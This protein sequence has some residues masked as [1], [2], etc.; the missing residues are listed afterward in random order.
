MMR[1]RSVFALYL[2]LG[3][4]GPTRSKRTSKPDAGRSSGGLLP[5]SVPSRRP[6]RSSSHG[7]AI[8][9]SDQA[10]V[11]ELRAISE[12]KRKFLRREL[13]MSPQVMLG[14]CEDSRAAEP[15]E[16]V[17]NHHQEAGGRV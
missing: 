13:D 5:A 8:Q 3:A 16:D 17:Q 7:D 10:V 9:A 2:P 11:D 14:D 1:V 15:P 4:L 6:T 12:L